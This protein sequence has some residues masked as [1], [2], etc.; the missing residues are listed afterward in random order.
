MKKTYKTPRKGI[1]PPAQHRAGL[2]GALI[3][4]IMENREVRKRILNKHRYGIRKALLIEFTTPG[5]YPK[6]FLSIYLNLSIAKLVL[7]LVAGL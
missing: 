6:A 7:L 1:D 5:Y 4:M 3:S 2:R